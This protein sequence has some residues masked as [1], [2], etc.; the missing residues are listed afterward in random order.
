MHVC[1]HVHRTHSLLCA[2]AP[3]TPDTS[4]I[5]AISSSDLPQI[6]VLLLCGSCCRASRS[7]SASLSGLPPSPEA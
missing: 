6:T 4:C 7:V 2:V 1:M 3:R 5:L